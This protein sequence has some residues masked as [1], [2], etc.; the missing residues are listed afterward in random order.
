MRFLLELAWQDLRASGRSLWIFC[1][2]LVLGV[3]LIT[4]SG[5]L[6]K[7]VETGLLSDTRALLGGDLE[8]DVSTPLPDDA[9]AWINQRGEVSLVMEVNTMLG[10]ST[11]DFLRVELQSTADN[12]PLYGQLELNPTM[13]L[14]DATRQTNGKWGVALDPVLA[15][16]LQVKVD[17]VVLIGSLEMVIRALV[18]EQPD[19]N[20]S[21]NWRG[22]PVLLSEDALMASGLIQPGSRIDYEYHVRTDTDAELW[23]EEF[24]AAFP[25]QAWEVRT[26]KDR[27]ERI[28]RR[29]EQIASG[30]MLIGFS[31]LFI[32]GLGVFNSIQSYLQTK[33]G[34]IATLQALGLREKRLAL[35]YLIQVGILSGF[36]SLVGAAIGSL[37]AI[38][39]TS[40]AA[41]ELP[42]TASLAGLLLPAVIAV[43]FGVLTAYTFALPA[44]GRA[45]S[46]QPAVLFRGMENAD[47]KLSAAW[48]SAT[49][50]GAGMIIFLFMSTVPDR[51]F[52][53]G[54][55]AVAALML[56]ILDGVVYILKFLARR[57]ESHSFLSTHFSVKLA[58]ANLYRPGAPLRISLLSLG[59]ALTLLVACTI[60][61][62]SIVRAINAT[63]PNE[64]PSLV[65]YDVF[66]YQL[67]DV[68]DALSAG[69]TLISQGSS[70]TD[71]TNTRDVSSATRVDKAPLVRA[72]M[73]AINGTPLRDVTGL[74][75]D[76][77]RDA[78]EDEYK[79]SYLS[80]NIDSVNII[81]GRWWSEVSEAT[82]QQVEDPVM[83]MED[84]E[85]NQ[86]GL[87]V[88]DRITFTVE[89][90][91]LEAEIVAI[92]SQ[93]GLQT[94][95]WF[96]GIMSQGALDGL[97]HR[98]VGAAYM[99]DQDAIQA[100][101]NIA[102][103][104]PNVITVRTATIL[105]TARDLLG[106]ATAG[107][108]VVAGVSLTV[109]LLVLISVMAAGRTRQIYDAT[110]L[111]SLG[112]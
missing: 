39:G 46:I 47:T 60:V 99:S 5:S 26:F 95:F 111:H 100:Q 59:S 41:T 24:Y 14:A 51:L 20:L 102:H 83:A 55:I 79:L 89:G 97:I 110:V 104:A 2:C 94:R 48:K 27:S 88:G 75:K 87:Q 4:A 1:T 17:D 53:L 7:L 96:E 71:T 37:L 34:T 85:A 61:V 12:Y 107:L 6:Y 72:R 62:A 18:L 29:L 105:E 19:R 82:Q 28:A 11:G 78:L 77:L 21:A 43:L 90:R 15:E 66:P 63:I 65:L 44:I 25:D 70:G 67:K 10:T 93:K 91:S 81:E 3:C 74:E 54:F 8:V 23:R 13:T 30:L 80:N 84:R 68:T 106:K 109:S 38:A 40:V 42:V 103:I 57:L 9:L 50:T 64:S 32:G 16:K 33:M 69:T 112:A 101:T 73:S 86:L 98:Y 58:V 52:G 45:L 92:Y 49:L 76:D 35:V 36:S 56:F 22:A 108:L 31:T